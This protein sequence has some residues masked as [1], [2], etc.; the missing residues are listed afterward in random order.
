MDTTQLKATL[1]NLINNRTDELAVFQAALSIL[2]STYKP[3]F[4]ALI[5]AQKE[6]DDGAAKVADLT[7]QITDI[8][9]KLDDATSQLSDANS[10]IA[11]LSKLVEMTPP[12][13]EK[14]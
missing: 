4:D 8:Q 12:V 1:Q 7:S 5:T 3:N 6:A 10:Q 9:V 13:S 11:T 14:Q 2:D